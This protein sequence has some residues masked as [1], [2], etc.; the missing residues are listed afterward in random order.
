MYEY[1]CILQN[2]KQTYLSEYDIDKE[3]LEDLLH[4]VMERIGFEHGLDYEL[5]DNNDESFTIKLI[6]NESNN[7]QSYGASDSEHFD[8]RA[9]KMLLNTIDRELARSF[10][11][12]TDIKYSYRLK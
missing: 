4:K 11:E 5:I 10:E 12:G 1:H 8:D 9:S 7:E 2:S 6:E 3:Q